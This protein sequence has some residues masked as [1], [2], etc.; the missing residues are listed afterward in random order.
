MISI[1]ENEYCN[2]FTNENDDVTVNKFN[3]GITNMWHRRLGHV[4][5]SY[6]QSLTREK[7]VTRI[8]NEIGD[9][10]CEAYKTYKLFRKP[11]VLCITKVRKY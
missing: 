5:D 4:N 9:T 1:I 10:N 2:E 3:E 6:V 11:R 7:L 8:Y